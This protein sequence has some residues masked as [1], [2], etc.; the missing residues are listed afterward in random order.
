MKSKKKLA[1]LFQAE[2]MDGRMDRERNTD[3]DPKNRTKK[4]K[5]ETKKK[6]D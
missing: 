6:I 1:S 5:Q 3:T 2:R 4:R